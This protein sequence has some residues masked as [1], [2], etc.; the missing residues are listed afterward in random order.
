MLWRL[1][2]SLSTYALTSAIKKY[3]NCTDYQCSSICPSSNPHS[4][5][6][7]IRA[8]RA[9]KP[10][11]SF[12]DYVQGFEGGILAE[13][14]R[15]LLTQNVSYPYTMKTALSMAVNR[16]SSDHNLHKVCLCYTWGQHYSIY[17]KRSVVEAM[18]TQKN[19]PQMMHAFICLLNLFTR[20]C[21][22]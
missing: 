7:Y 8:E 20:R 13:S 14:E 10:H 17:Q 3:I 12:Q 16:L 15:L 2:I 22:C 5:G 9:H 6:F 21:D 19:T 1:S 18:F 11:Y 4:A